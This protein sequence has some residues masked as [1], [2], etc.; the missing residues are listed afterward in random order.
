[1]EIVSV[2][3]G[4]PRSVTIAGKVVST[5][6]YKQAVDRRVMVRALDL[7]GDAQAD[8]EAHGGVDQAVYAYPFEHYDYWAEAL[9]RDDFRPGQ[10]GE[11]LTIR[12][13]DESRVRVGDSFRAGD[14]VLQATQPRIPCIKLAHRMACGPDFSKRFLR[15]GRTGFHFR[16]LR[17]GELQSGD[18]IEVVNTDPAAVT[19]AEFIRIS[20]FDN[21]DA[22]GLARILASPGLSAEWRERLTNQL[23]K[24]TKGVRPG[25]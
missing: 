1:M 18:P 22:T 25:D 19:I 5:A 8:R 12:G 6:I 23:R 21:R 24:A 9:N 13:L 2:N 20:Q 17:E 3:V 4:R 16:I 15:S 7:E 14:V 11:N 10:F